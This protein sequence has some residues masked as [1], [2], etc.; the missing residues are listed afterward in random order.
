[1]ANFEENL[2]SIIQKYTEN[3][4]GKSYSE[5]SEEI[6]VLMEAFGISQELK[7][8]N[9]QYWGRELGMCW[10]LLVTEVFRNF[11]KD[12]S[13]PKRYGSDEPADFFAGQ[14]AVDTKYRVGSGD[15]GTLK[16]FKQ[17]GEMLKSEGLNPVFLF[18]RSDNLPAAISACKVGGWSIYMGDDSFKYI[19]E[20]TGFD[21]KE[22][23][24]NIKNYNKHKIERL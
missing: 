14:D 20:R 12:F 15:S 1:M 17:Y 10:Q 19:F 22:W 23:L 8:E 3:F 11:C 2:L 7:K 18:L 16:K 13:P 5:E 24:I 9:K 4:S 6:D 21:L